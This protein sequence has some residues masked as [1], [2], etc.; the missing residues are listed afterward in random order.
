MAT[1]FPCL[2]CLD[3][4]QYADV[5]GGKVRASLFVFIYCKKKKNL[6]V[7]MT[8]EQGE[9]IAV[10]SLELPALSVL[11]LRSISLADILPVHMNS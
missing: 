11:H 5:E 9:A 1:S 4:F 3:Y 2:Q 7:E 6:E 8:S 10:S